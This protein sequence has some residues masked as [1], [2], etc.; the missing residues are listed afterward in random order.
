M[1]GLHPVAFWITAAILAVMAI[2]P[3]IFLVLDKA[4][5]LSPALGS[6]LWTRYQSWLVLAPLLVAPLLIHR[7]TAIIG[8]GLLSLLCYREFSRATGL[9]RHRAISAVVVL[10]IVLI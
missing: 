4:G 1:F 5:K 2:T 9:F 8:V 7:L 10:G 6:D 3:I